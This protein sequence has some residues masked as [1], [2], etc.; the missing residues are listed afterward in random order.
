MGQAHWPTLKNLPSLTPGARPV[1]AGHRSAALEMALGGMDEEPVSDTPRLILCLPCEECA[2]GSFR[3][4]LL[5]VLKVLC[6]LWGSLV[7][8]RA[9]RLRLRG[10]DWARGEPSSSMGT[11]V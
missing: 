9:T 1:R 2:V 10:C 11:A 5:L 3:A 6:F 8:R 4:P 7:S